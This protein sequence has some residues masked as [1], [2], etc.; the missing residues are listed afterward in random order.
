[1]AI[2][3]KLDDVPETRTRKD[4]VRRFL[5]K[6][7]PRSYSDAACTILQCDYGKYR[8]ITELHEIV[9]SRFPKT[10]FDAMIRIVGELIAEDAGVSMVYCTQ[11]NKVVLKY[12]D[13]PTRTYMTDYSRKNFL[14]K[15]G[16]DG[17]SLND[18]EKIKEN[19]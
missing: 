5:N 13:R 19:L 8:S 14:T 18:Y 12:F 17:Y 16:V 9:M 3:V 1:M 6:T 4:L 11:V 7:S 2:Y 10:T 15:K